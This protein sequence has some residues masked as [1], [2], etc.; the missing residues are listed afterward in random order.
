MSRTT[1][2]E[3]AH[4]KGTEAC[5]GDA[6]IDNPNIPTREKTMEIRKKF[7]WAIGI[8]VALIV[9]AALVVYP[10]VVAEAPKDDAQLTEIKFKG[11]MG[12]RYTEILLVFGNALTKQLHGRCLQHPRPERRQSRRWR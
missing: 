10:K 11:L 7:V 12:S 1:P 2:G 8:V 9:V 5:E 6:Q 3:P 4:A